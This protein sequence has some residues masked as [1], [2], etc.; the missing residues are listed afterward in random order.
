[1]VVGPFM[2]KEEVNDEVMLERQLWHDN[3]A[4]KSMEL[5]NYNAMLITQHEAKEET[6]K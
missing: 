6:W 2:I 4:L 1:M 5:F 3:Q